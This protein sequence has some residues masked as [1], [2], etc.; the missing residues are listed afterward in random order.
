MKENKGKI[1]RKKKTNKGKDNKKPVK[2]NILQEIEDTESED[3]NDELEWY[4][5]ICCDSYSNSKSKKNRIDCVMCKNWNH[6]KCIK[7]EEHVT[8]LCPNCR[9]DE[10]FSD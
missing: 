1:Q 2:R 5:I 9:S 10:S 6:L 3:E 7:D 8:F 4:C